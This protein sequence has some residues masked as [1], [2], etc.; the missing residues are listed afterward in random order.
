MLKSD[1]VCSNSCDD[2][3]SNI[4]FVQLL[5]YNLVAQQT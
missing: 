5:M 4:D 1:A 3:E 2:Y